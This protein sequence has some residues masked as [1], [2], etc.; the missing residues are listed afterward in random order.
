MLSDTMFLSFSDSLLVFTMEVQFSRATSPA[1]LWGEKKVLDFIV[2]KLL[3]KSQRGINYFFAIM[4]GKS[5]G[6][7]AAGFHSQIVLLNIS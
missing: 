4:F 3:H 1:L 2:L 5:I 7:I 6:Y